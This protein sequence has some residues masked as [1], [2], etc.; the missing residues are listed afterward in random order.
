MVLLFIFTI[1]LSLL[2]I[3]GIRINLGEE[4]LT[5]WRPISAWVGQFSSPGCRRRTQVVIEESAYWIHLGVVLVFLTELPGGKHF[6]VVTSIPAVFL[7]NLE[8]PG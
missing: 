5:A 2:V 8:S 4:P 1:M 3:N 7:R 6:H